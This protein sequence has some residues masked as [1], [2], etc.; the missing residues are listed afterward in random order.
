MKSIC[1]FFIL[2][3]VE[4]EG[5]DPSTSWWTVSPVQFYCGVVE[6]N[7]SWS[8]NKHCLCCCAATHSVLHLK[9]VLLSDPGWFSA[10]SIVQAA[11]EFVILLLSLWSNWNYVLVPSGPV[12]SV[13]AICFETGSLY[14]AQAGLELGI[15]LS[16]APE[17][18]DC[19]H[20]S[21]YLAT[22]NSVSWF[23]F[24]CNIFHVSNLKFTKYSKAVHKCTR[25]YITT[26]WIEWWIWVP[27]P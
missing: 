8:V 5:E 13:I 26:L 27:S 22:C 18:W 23:F 25:I 17:W 12:Q 11:F 2:I 10:H 4:G 20:A 14:M 16:H 24:S 1:K 19:T 9:T 3:E 6:L 7:H 15:S 21:P